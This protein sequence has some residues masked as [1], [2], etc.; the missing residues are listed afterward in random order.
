MQNLPSFI[1]LA[2][3]WASRAEFFANSLRIGREACRRCKSSE[4]H[5][6]C[7]RLGFASEF[8]ANSL[9]RSAKHSVAEDAKSSEFHCLCRRL[10][11]TVGIFCKFRYGKVAKPVEDANLPSFITLAVDWASRR[12]FLQ[13]R[14]GEA[15]STQ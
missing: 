15:R 8:F 10:G 4:F 1:A 7:C 9:R 11:F 12:N 3:G 5:Y 14:Y 2:V 13:I 6:P